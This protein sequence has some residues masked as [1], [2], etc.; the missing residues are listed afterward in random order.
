L[1]GWAHEQGLSVHWR[2][3]DNWAIVEG[4]AEN[5]ASAFDVEVHDYRGQRGQVFYASPQQPSVLP[6]LR[7]EVTGFGRILSYLPHR[8]SKPSI[9]SLDVPNKGLTP[10]ALLTTY[11]VNKLAADGYAGKGITIVIFA[12]DGYDQ[13]DLD[14]FASTYGLPEVHPDSGRRPARRAA[15]R[16]DDG[17]R[18][19]PGPAL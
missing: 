10:S 1:V 13:A 3:G 11:N 7:G 15:R 16:D 17:P 19:G 2:P 14:T 8:M 12:F 6:E 5:V 18:S 9:L 4:N